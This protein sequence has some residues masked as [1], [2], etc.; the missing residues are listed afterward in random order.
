MG[1]M[2]MMMQAIMGGQLDAAIAAA[3]ILDSHGNG[4]VLLDVQHQRG[5]QV[6]VPDP[7]RLK[8]GSGD[9]GGLEDGEDDLEEDLDGVAAVDHGS[10]FDL[11]GDALHEAGEHEHGQTGTEPDR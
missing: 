9:H 4:A 7:H 2:A 1:M 8:D 11:D 10:L 3:E 6:V 5:Q